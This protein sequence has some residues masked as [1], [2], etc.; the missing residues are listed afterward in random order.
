MIAVTAKVK[1]DWSAVNKG[2]TPCLTQ[3]VCS[4][5]DDKLFMTTH[6]RSQDM[7]HG[8][9]RN[10]FSL[11][12]LQKLI[13]DLSG[14]SMGAFVMITHSAHIYSDDYALVEKI[15]KENYETEL[16]YTSRQMFEDDPRGNIVISVEEA[17]KHA[18]GRPTKNAVKPTHTSFEIVVKLYAPNGGLLLHEWRGSSAME[19][20]IDMV[21][22]GS[23]LY[24]QAI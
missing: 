4:I 16:G 1:E 3:I 10:V 5:Q 18:V 2:D 9:P 12:K 13:C 22:I 14:V 24:C 20:Y 17:S 21:N 8:W 7:V 6:F 11:R 19:V 15:L 23:I